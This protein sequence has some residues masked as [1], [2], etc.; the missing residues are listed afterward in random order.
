MTENLKL[1]LK[2]NLNLS[3]LLPKGLIVFLVLVLCFLLFSLFSA[4]SN[5]EPQKAQLPLLPK[6]ELPKRQLP[7]KE[8]PSLS[9]KTNKE[10]DSYHD[11]IV[12]VVVKNTMGK[13][14]LPQQI[15]NKLNLEIDT[16]INNQLQKILDS[17]TEYRIDIAATDS[18]GI[19]VFR[20]I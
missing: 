7:K 20:K 5:N 1:R 16:V 12:S 17:Y 2:S 15:H 13:Y 4:E 18:T 3:Q 8:I 6:K 11:K 9:K 10:T 19:L 14:E